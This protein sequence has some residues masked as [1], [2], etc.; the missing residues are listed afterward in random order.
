[1][2]KSSVCGPHAVR[3]EKSR[4]YG[5]RCFETNRKSTNFENP[6]GPSANRSK[7]IPKKTSARLRPLKIDLWLLPTSLPRL[8]HRRFEDFWSAQLLEKLG[9]Q[10]ENRSFLKKLCPPTLRYSGPTSKTENRFGGRGKVPSQNQ[11]KSPTPFSLE[12][13]RP[14]PPKLG[15]ELGRVLRTKTPAKRWF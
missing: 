4:R 2:R 5:H 14:P 10:R 6:V 9:G 13:K 1:M 11:L 3:G 12:E 8:G 7:T 15:R